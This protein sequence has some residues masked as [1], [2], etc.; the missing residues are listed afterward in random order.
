MKK[1]IAMATGGVDY[2]A[3]LDEVSDI[4]VTYP[5]EEEEKEVDTTQPFPM[6]GAASTPYHGGEQN[7][8]QTMMREQSGLPSYDESTPLLST[9]DIERRLWDLRTNP[10]TGIIDTTQ[11]DTS[12]PLSEEDRAEQI[13]RVKGFIKAQYPNA[14]FD[15]L[16]IG[17]STKNPMDIVALGPKGGETKIVLNDGSGLQKSFLNLTYVK[18]ALGQQAE[19][20]IEEDRNTAAQQRQR[21]EEAE[22]QLREA[23]KISSERKQE[24]EEI[25]VLKEK[26]EAVQAKIDAIQEVEGSNL[27]SESELRRL[28]QLKKN[29]QTDIKNKEKKLA[30]REKKAKNEQKKIKEKVDQERKKFNKIEKRK[31]IT[32]ERLYETKRLD[33]LK[34][35]VND[36]NSQNEEYQAII[37]DENATPSEREFAKSRQAEIKEEIA[38]LQTQVDERVAEMPLRERVREIFKKYGVTVTAIFLAAGITIGAVVGAITNALKSMGNQLANGL[39]T[40]G[41]KAA[42]ALPGLIGAIVS[43]LFKTAGQ[44]IGY[45]AEHT[46][47]LILAAVV[48][49][50]E[51]YIKKR[52]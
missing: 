43:F 37:Q 17:F 7:E 31:K 39:K 25:K 4:K 18:R 44:A 24:E 1:Y 9:S 3:E 38:R 49:I 11:M 12:N 23:E 16:P 47:L 19:Q 28:K 14:N 41:A 13:E 6:P 27:E 36:L 30:D 33:E 48:F 40:V 29:Y 52:R 35:R 2:D 46:W 50:F 45:L 5:S 42:S 20:I 34:E 15:H 21:L 8:M 10:R 51:K 26:E 32:E 22:K